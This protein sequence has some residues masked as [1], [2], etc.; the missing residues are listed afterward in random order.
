MPTEESFD[1]EEYLRRVVANGLAELGRL[2]AERHHD[3]VKFFLTLL[4]GASGAFV[5]AGVLG[6]DAAAA[7]ERKVAAPLLETGHFRAV[8][9]RADSRTEVTASASPTVTTR[10]A[11][12]LPGPVEFRFDLTALGLP[13]EGSQARTRAIDEIVQAVEKTAGLTVQRCG[14][15]LSAMSH[16]AEG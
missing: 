10:P 1:A 2:P 4:Q 7:V 5:A 3:T 8:E 14:G 11:T 13:R 9:A 15:R 12:R 6:R 16:I